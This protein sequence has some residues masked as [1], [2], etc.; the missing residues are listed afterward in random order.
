MSTPEHDKRVADTVNRHVSELRQMAADGEISDEDHDTAGTILTHHIG[1]LIGLSAKAWATF[2]NIV[3][4]SRE[5][6][7]DRSHEANPRDR[8][9]LEPGAGAMISLAV[10]P[11]TPSL[12]ITITGPT[13]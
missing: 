11:A 2:Q 12:S 10:S 6:H 13:N 5:V 3:E 4:E 1:H 8:E 9:R 7:Y